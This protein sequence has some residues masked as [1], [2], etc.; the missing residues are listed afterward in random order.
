MPY[1]NP[2]RGLKAVQIETSRSPI[3]GGAKAQTTGFTAATPFTAKS[4]AGIAPN[5]SWGHAAGFNDIQNLR[6]L[7][8][9]RSSPSSAIRCYPP[10]WHA[11]TS[12]KP[13][14]G[15]QSMKSESDGDGVMKSTF[16][17]NRHEFA[18][19]CSRQ[20]ACD[21]NSVTQIRLGLSV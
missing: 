3:F 18:L 10:S 7:A 9:A 2:L 15:H 1:C 12:S 11:G 14:A 13:P 20:P 16:D 4:C 19:L 6:R 5:C 17:I 21:D 8:E